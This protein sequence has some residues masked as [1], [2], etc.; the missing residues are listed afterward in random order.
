MGALQIKRFQF[1]NANLD[2]FNEKIKWNS[3]IIKRGFLG[4]MTAE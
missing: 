2:K 1:E 4:E 3:G